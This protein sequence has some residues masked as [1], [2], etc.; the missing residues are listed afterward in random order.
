MLDKSINE[1]NRFCLFAVI[2]IIGKREMAA[3]WKM[4]GI[5]LLGLVIDMALSVRQ[6]ERIVLVTNGSM[7]FEERA[8]H[9]RIHLLE[10][11]N[12]GQTLNL[13]YSPSSIL[14]Q[15]VKRLEE[16]SAQKMCC[17][18]LVI[19]DPLCPLRKLVHIQNAIELYDSQFDKPRPWL[20]VKSVNLVPN[21][22]HPKKILMLTQEGDLDYYDPTGQMI[23]RRQQLEGDNSY[24]INQAVHIVDP[25]SLETQSL[26][27][28]EIL[29]L[30]IDDPMVVVEE[31]EDLDLA[32][33]LSLCVMS[34]EIE[35]RV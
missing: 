9:P 14:P 24:C 4:R 35:S 18:G 29:G 28:E 6:I 19:L 12:S 31:K 5:S 1:S 20:S 32:K 33:A 27:N 8:E 21:H 22:Y 25:M 10:I 23:Y 13:T 34:D 7:T 11:E 30:I 15:I 17:N 2:P 16:I 3:S 26:E